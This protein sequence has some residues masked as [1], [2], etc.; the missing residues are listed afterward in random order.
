MILKTINL[1]IAK[2]L[3]KLGKIQ[4]KPAKY[5]V[6]PRKFYEYLW[7]KGYQIKEKYY[8]CPF[9]AFKEVSY[10]GRELTDIIEKE[11]LGPIFKTKI[12]EN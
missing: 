8:I 7:D 4:F 3:I 5:R 2:I 12:S 6:L 1:F 9:A 11:K 10:R